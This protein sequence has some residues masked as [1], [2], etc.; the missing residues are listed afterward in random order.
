M[1]A[2]VLLRNIS[3]YAL[4]FGLNNYQISFEIENIF[5]FAI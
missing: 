5:T 1:V 2:Q 4:I 3:K